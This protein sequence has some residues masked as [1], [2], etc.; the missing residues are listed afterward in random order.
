MVHTKMNVSELDENYNCRTL[1]SDNEH[2]SKIVDRLSRLPDGSVSVR[3]TAD[4]EL[5]SKFSKR[6]NWDF[7]VSGYSDDRL[8]FEYVVGN[9]TYTITEHIPDANYRAIERFYRVA[10]SLTDKDS[11]S[12]PKI[13]PT[14]TVVDIPIDCRNWFS[15]LIK[16]ILFDTK[17]KIGFPTIL[18]NEYMCIPDNG[19]RCGIEPPMQPFFKSPEY[20]N[21]HCK[22]NGNPKWDVHIKAWNQLVSIGLQSK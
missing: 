1:F 4:G 21:K 7:K 14:K 2:L 9:K 6:V 5:I 20:C 19:C 17:M 12:I 22:E 18:I 10:Y 16:S 3:I 8:I 15:A 13:R 11:V